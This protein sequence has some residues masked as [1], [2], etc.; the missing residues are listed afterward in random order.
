[1]NNLTKNSNIAAKDKKSISI[2]ELLI[3]K[4]IIV[5]NINSVL[6][7]DSGYKGKSY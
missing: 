1:M 3:I 6:N 2:L 7:G 4:I 5:V